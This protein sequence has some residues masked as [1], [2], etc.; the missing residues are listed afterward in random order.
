MNTF[1][2]GLAL[3]L[4]ISGADVVCSAQD[5]QYACR[6]VNCIESNAYMR[7]SVIGECRL[8]QSGGSA[9]NGPVKRNADVQ[10]KPLTQYLLVEVHGRTMGVSFRDRD[11][12]DVLLK[13]LGF[14]VK[15]GKMCTHISEEDDDMSGCGCPY[16]S[17][18]RPGKTGVT[19]LEMFGGE[20][21][22]CIIDFANQDEL[23][24]FVQ[25]MLVSD[26][27]LYNGIYSHPA[28]DDWGRIYVRVTG[29][30]VKIMDPWEMLPDDF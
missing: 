19:K 24:A 29:L 26:Y 12:I 22:T 18:T 11:N 16:L 3:L 4:F 30:R 9:K 17:A 27:T 23:D 13:K 14:R 8:D 10:I 25:S 1:F 28:N 6:G 7:M 2:K 15:T 5:F 20:D 21:T